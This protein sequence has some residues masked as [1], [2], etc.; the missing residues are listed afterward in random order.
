MREA[1]TVP[2]R[3]RTWNSTRRAERKG[4]EIALYGHHPAPICDLEVVLVLF[5]RF[6]DYFIALARASSTSLRRAF[7]ISGTSVRVNAYA[8]LP[9][10][11]VA[12]IS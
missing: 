2:D 5:K 8:G 7:S 10:G 9:S 3:K 6:R 12:R 1:S 11:L 4:D